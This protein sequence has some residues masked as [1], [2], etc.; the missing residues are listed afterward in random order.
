METAF[1]TG[2]KAADIAGIRTIRQAEQALRDAGLPAD[3]AK[4][5]P[6]TF[7]HGQLVTIPSSVLLM[8]ASAELSIIE[9]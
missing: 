1:V 7:E 5:L 3:A 2:V 4:P 8:M 9:R 6:R